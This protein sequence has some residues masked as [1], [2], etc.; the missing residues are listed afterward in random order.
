MKEYLIIPILPV[1]LIIIWAFIAKLRQK[2]VSNAL[3]VLIA[4]LTIVIN[5]YA[6]YH[7]VCDVQVP[8]WIQLAQLVLSPTIVPQAY[9]YFCRQ[10][11]SKGSLS[12]KI[13]LWALLLFLFVPSISIDLAPISE[14]HT[15][16]ATHLLNF[17]IYRG[18]ELLY[19]ISIPSIII[20]IQAFL[21]SV[22]IPVMASNMRRYGLKIGF[23]GRSFLTWW[24]LAIGFIC[25]S[26]LIS[27]DMLR[28]PSFSWFFFISYSFLS[29]MIFGHIALRLDII[30]IQ[31]IDDEEAIDNVDAFIHDNHEL[32]E[33]AKRLFLTEKLFLRPGIVIDDVV[34]MLGT[35]RTYFTRMMRTEF[36]MSFNEYITKE[37]ITYS[38]T[39]LS[40]TDKTLD[41]IALECGFSNASAYI[42]VFKRVTDSTPDTWRKTID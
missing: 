6:V 13:T 35:N 2:E 15:Q 41:E 1:V 24:V 16:A 42:R 21:T 14:A 3:I 19:Y 9:Y 28:N 26:S 25:F 37:R 33:K 29:A 38:Q 23:A 8:L 40:N 22:R 32:A 27:L 39:L 7:L 36:N 11:G 34:H 30:P 4:G 12:I 10:I 18:G 17:N 5:A 31:T 20:L